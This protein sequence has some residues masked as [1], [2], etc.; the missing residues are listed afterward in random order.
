MF[1]ASNQQRKKKR[2]DIG[3]FYVKNQSAK[4]VEETFQHINVS[5]IMYHCILYAW[6]CITKINKSYNL[7]IFINIYIFNNIKIQHYLKYCFKLFKLFFSGL[8]LWF[9]GLTLSVF[10]IYVFSV[11]C[12]N[13]RCYNNFGAI[14]FGV[15]LTT[16]GI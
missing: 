4:C 1:T 14:F 13:F 2:M 15:P 8:Y 7:N 6:K 16:K 9:L 10:S 3:W 11:W 5:N 12:Y